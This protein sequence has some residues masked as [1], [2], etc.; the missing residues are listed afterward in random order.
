MSPTDRSVGTVGGVGDDG[1]TNSG[2][3]RGSSPRPPAAGGVAAAR[4]TSR[5]SNAEGNDPRPCAAV[6]VLI[7]CECEVAAVTLVAPVILSRDNR[8][9]ARDEADDGRRLPCTDAAA[10]ASAA[11]AALSLTRLH[12]LAIV[13]RASWLY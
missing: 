2:T 5:N 8:D 3:S 9:D 12:I 11:A 13:S 10:A 7:A 6:P 4:G 1:K